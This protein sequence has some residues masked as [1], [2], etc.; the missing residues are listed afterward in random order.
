MKIAS[1]S[2]RPKS[3]SQRHREAALGRDRPATSERPPRAVR[4]SFGIELA[5]PQRTRLE[6]GAAAGDARTGAP[7]GSACPRAR[8][9]PCRRP[10]RRRGRARAGRVSGRDRATSPTRRAPR[11][12]SRARARSR[13]SGGRARRCTSSG[14]IGSPA[15]IATPPETRYA[16]NAVRSSEKKYDLSRT[17]RERRDRVGAVLRDERVR[18]LALARLLPQPVAPGREPFDEEQARLRPTRSGTRRAGTSRRAAR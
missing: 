8:R 1:S 13:G 7:C 2:P 14:P 17:E 15:T 6:A 18:L 9:P 11:R 10:P 16:R 12:A 5:R 3:A 4:A